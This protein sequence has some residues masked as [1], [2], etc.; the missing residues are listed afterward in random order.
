MLDAS[1][2]RAG[3]AVASLKDAMRDPRSFELAEVDR[4]AG[5]ALCI[6][7]RARNGFGGM[8]MARAFV[9]V[10]VNRVVLDTAY[11]FVAMW[12]ASCRSLYDITNMV[13]VK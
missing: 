4:A 1:S 8:N 5:G 7:Y 3:T 2:I 11:G 9:P 10:G 12:N 6:I 13:Y